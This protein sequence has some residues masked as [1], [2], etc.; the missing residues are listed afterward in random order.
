VLS[1]LSFRTCFRPPRHYIG[2]LATL[3]RKN[4]QNPPG[5]IA[6][7]QIASIVDEGLAKF[8]IDDHAL[9]RFN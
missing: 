8:T 9:E 4:I 2:W 6:I 7:H 5:A 3:Q 1:Q